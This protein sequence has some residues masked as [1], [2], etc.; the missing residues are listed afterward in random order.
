VRLPAI[1]E[2]ALYIH[3]AHGSIGRLIRCT[4]MLVCDFD[5]NFFPTFHVLCQQMGLSP[6]VV[7]LCAIVTRRHQFNLENTD[8]L[9]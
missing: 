1:L 8:F 5:F 9:Y 3:V 6:A 4:T 2:S 7:W